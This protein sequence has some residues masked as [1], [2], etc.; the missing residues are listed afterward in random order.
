MTVGCG[1][2]DWQP[3]EAEIT[4]ANFETHAQTAHDTSEF[5]TKM[6][7]LCPRDSTPVDFRGVAQGKALYDCPKCKRTYETRIRQ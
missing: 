4:E 7:V 3:E 6:R 5:V 2:C 1:S